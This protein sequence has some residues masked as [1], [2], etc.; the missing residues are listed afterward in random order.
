VVRR[1]ASGRQTIFPPGNSDT[2]HAAAQLIAAI[3]KDN[4]RPSELQ[5]RLNLSNA[6]CDRL[7]SLLYMHG[8]IEHA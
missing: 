8:V 3:G 1:T 5:D 7:L 6:E 4:A 2:A